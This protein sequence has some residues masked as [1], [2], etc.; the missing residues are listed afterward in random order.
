VVKYTWK[1]Y[2]SLQVEL[3]PIEFGVPLRATPADLRARIEQLE[4]AMFKAAPEH[5]V[6]I[7]PKHYFAKGLYG[8]EITIPTGTLLTGKIHKYEHINFL[9]KGDISVLTEQGIKRIQAPA[10]LISPPGTK[11]I[12][13]AHSEVLWTTVHATEEKDPDQAELA[14][15][16][17]TYEQFEQFL[18][19]ESKKCLT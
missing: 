3:K 16:C 1:I 17:A 12:G 10:T 7:P 9:L 11:R 4:R 6:E 13:Y 5:G 2:W 19:E 8:R 18:L 15:V 14:L